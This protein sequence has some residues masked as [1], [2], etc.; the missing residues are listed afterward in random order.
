MVHCEIHKDLPPEPLKKAVITL[1][2]FNYRMLDFDG[3]VASFKPVVDGMVQ[4]GVLIDD[5][6]SVTGRWHVDQRFSPKGTAKIFVRV[7]EI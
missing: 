4:A 3:L 6:W 7:E 5:R 2:R 1:I